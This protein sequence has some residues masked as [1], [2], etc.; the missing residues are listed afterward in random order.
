MEAAFL[1]SLRSNPVHPRPYPSKVK[2]LKRLGLGQKMEKGGWAGPRLVPSQAYQGLGIDLEL[3]N[4]DDL[5]WAG[6]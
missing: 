4:R 6:R 2:G 5:D 3:Q 1:L